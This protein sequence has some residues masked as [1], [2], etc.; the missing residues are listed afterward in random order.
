MSC[1]IA[2]ERDP[3]ERSASLAKQRTNVFRNKARDIKGIL[4]AGF[5]GLRAD[6]VTVIKCDRA[7]AL[8]IEH[9]LHV[10]RHR[11]ASNA[12]CIRSGITAAQRH[13]FRQ[14]HFVGT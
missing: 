4:Y 14:R 12:S 13:R 5:F 6:I 3:A 10:H 9:G 7:F 1:W 8:Q 11:L 2:A